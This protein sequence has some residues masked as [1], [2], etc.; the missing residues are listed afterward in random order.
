MVQINELIKLAE[1]L[2]CDKSTT[3]PS[4]SIETGAVRIAILQRGWVVVGKFRKNGPQ[5]FLDDASVV[6]TWGTTRGL[7][8]IALNGPTDSTRLDP[9]GTVEFHELAAVAIMDCDQT[10]WEGKLS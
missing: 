4:T 1:L 8:E 9:C 3:A 2:E 5:C 7:G 6:R 10:K